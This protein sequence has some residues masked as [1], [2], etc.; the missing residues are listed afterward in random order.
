MIAIVISAIGTVGE[1][2]RAL[3][4]AMFMAALFLAAVGL[5]L[6]IIWGAGKWFKNW[7]LYSRHPLAKR[8]R[9]FLRERR[10]AKAVRA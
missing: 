10:Q 5:W 4:V 8:I 1:F 9:T 7:R 6:A 2:A 3:A